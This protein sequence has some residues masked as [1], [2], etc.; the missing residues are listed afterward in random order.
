MRTLVT[1]ML[2]ALVAAQD[3]DASDS[4]PQIDPFPSFYHTTEDLKIQ[5]YELSRSC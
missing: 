4:G 5:L 1:L 2:I 3:Q